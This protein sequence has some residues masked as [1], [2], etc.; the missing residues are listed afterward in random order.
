ML[1]KVKLVI[2]YDNFIELSEN[3]EYKVLSEETLLEKNISTGYQDFIKLVTELK[4]TMFSSDVH[5]NLTDIVYNE[6]FLS[7]IYK[8]LNMPKVTVLKKQK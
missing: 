8:V 6:G 7:V 2:E 5:R 1:F 4:R 3:T